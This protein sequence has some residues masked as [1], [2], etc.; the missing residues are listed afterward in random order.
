MND[1]VCLVTGGSSGIGKETVRGL[2]KQGA[3]VLSVSRP[4]PRGEEAVQEIRDDSGNDNV[5][6]F[7]ADLSLMSEVR[8]LAH[9]VSERFDKLD[10]LVNNAGVF[11]KEYEE[12]PDGFE[13]TFA[14]NHLAPFL[15]TVLLMPSLR[16]APAARIITV[17]SIAERQGKLHRDDPM[18][19]DNYGGWKAYAQSK[20]A[21][22]LFSYHLA[23]L[24]KDTDITANTLH[25]GAV[26]TNFGH[27]NSGWVGWLFKLLAPV[28]RSADKG[29][30]TVRYLAAS[31]EVEG[32]S[33]KYFVDCKAK[34][35]SKASFDEQDQAWLWEKSAAL[36]GLREDEQA[37]FERRAATPA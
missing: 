18:L 4:A 10:V 37:A 29:S 32:V 11:L 9:E 8:R 25:P 14:L 3:T 24:L 1:K 35:S 21:N 30:E 2:A 26:A 15:L 7:P 6:F 31:P 12:T 22:V 28:M 27:N 13:K 17:S 20:L 36:V 33:G 19:R 34:P 23:D 5:Y 16:A